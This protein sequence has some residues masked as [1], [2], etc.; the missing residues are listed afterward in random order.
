[1][2]DVLEFLQLM[3]GPA[4]VSAIVLW[5]V[6]SPRKCRSCGHIGKPILKTEGSL[7]IELLLWS[8]TIS[9][10]IVLGIPAFDGMGILKLP[11]LV[12]MLP[13]PIYTFMRNLSRKRVCA[14]CGSTNFGISLRRPP[15]IN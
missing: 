7:R 9:I 2:K 4:I 6:F 8:F 13:G 15:Y 11:F 12:L 14:K 1:M 10:P 3:I 5:V